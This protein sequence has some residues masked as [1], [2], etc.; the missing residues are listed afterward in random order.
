MFL[1]YCQIYTDNIAAV[2]TGITSFCVVLFK[3]RLE[4]DVALRAGNFVTP[5]YMTYDL[6]GFARS[7]NFPSSLR[8]LVNCNS[9]K[10]FKE[11]MSSSAFSKQLAQFPA[12]AVQ[13]DISCFEFSSSS[14][15]NLQQ[16]L[17]FKL[18]LVICSPWGQFLRRKPR[19]RSLRLFGSSMVF[20]LCLLEF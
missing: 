5:M 6:L 10:A 12:I 2:L 4:G 15:Q 1:S 13:L 17:C 3:F 14:Q 20:V 11:G 19:I 16:L 8:V 9:H 7:Y 18:I